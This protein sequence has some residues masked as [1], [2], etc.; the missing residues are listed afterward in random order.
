MSRS[1]R[2]RGDRPIRRTSSA[3]G[4][5]SPPRTRDRKPVDIFTIDPRSLPRARE[6][7]QIPLCSIAVLRMRL[8]AHA[9]GSTLPPAART[10]TGGCGLP[11]ARGDRPSVSIIS[12][13][14]ARSPR[15]REI[16]P[17]GPAH[18]H[19]GRVSPAHAGIDPEHSASPGA[20][21]VSPRAREIEPPLE[22]PLGA[23]KKSPRARI[24]L[25][26]LCRRSPGVGL[27]RTRGSTLR[28]LAALAQAD[29]SPR[30]RE[31]DR[32]RLIT[33]SI[34]SSMSPRARGDQPMLGACLQ[35][36]Q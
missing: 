11:R 30:A 12:I 8:P 24:D 10:L 34:R 25:A 6:D 20:H 19:R 1:P 31:E 7:R 17:L 22:L 16:G 35:C 32:Y 3:E 27:P 18:L 9:R 2:A 28:L 36:L 23:V 13:S 14:P 29:V 26:R 15:A 33:R 4:T 5:R 21:W